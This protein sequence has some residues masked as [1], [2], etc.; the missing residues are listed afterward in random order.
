MV[1]RCVIPL[2]L[3]FFF[4]FSVSCSRLDFAMKWADT[5]VMSSVTDYFELTSEQDDKARSEFN[6]ALK[7]VQKVDFP[8]FATQLT[9]FADLVEKKE[10]T[11]AKADNFFDEI[12]KTLMQSMARFEPM[13]QNMI[14]DQIKTDF[15]MFD[16]EFLR[17]HDKDLK[18]AKD[19]VEQIKKARKNVERFVDET[20]EILRPEQ[21][22]EIEDSI[23]N[24]PFPAVLQ[25]ES[26]KAMFEKFKLVR[27][28]PAQR[29]EFV[30]KYFVDWDSL[31]TADYK[32]SRNESLQKFRVWIKKVLGSLDDKQR[33]NLVKSFR[34]RADELKKISEK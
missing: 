15:K 10:M 13:A 27:Q 9:G 31:Q 29:K 5:F 20:V 8:I 2:M 3:F 24:D 4:L 26:R 32:K 18:A 16:K 22:K 21:L 1:K 11:D 25:M 34:G 12:H 23:K 7:E 19:Q 6:L 14:N 33:A 28:D 17:K 30:H